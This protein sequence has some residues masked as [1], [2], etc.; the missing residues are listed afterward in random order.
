MDK[1]VSVGEKSI[2]KLDLA[3]AKGKRKEDK[4]ENIKQREW[5]RQKSKILKENN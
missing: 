3:I 1:G 4:R 5:N 2:A